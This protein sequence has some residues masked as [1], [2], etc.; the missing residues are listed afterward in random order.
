MYVVD[1]LV[2]FDIVY[3]VFDGGECF[4]CVG[5]VV[6]CEEDVGYDLIDQDQ[7]CQ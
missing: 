1:Q 5:F 2:L 6:Y 4:G 3:D 7:Q